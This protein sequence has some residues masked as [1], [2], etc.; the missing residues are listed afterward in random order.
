M[1]QKLPGEK[2]IDWLGLRVEEQERRA[3]EERARR[4]KVPVSFVHRQAL[5][6]FLELEDP[7]DEYLPPIRERKG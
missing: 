2:R 6:Q 3:L 4:D 5:R 7:D 1:A